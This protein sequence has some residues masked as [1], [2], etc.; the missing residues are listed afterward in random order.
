MKLIFKIVLLS[1]IFV[2]QL[3][4]QVVNLGIIK[5]LDGYT[6]VREGKQNDSKVLA[7]IYEG[8]LFAVEKSS[9]NWWK[10]ITK[11][12]I[13]GYVHKSRI[14]IVENFKK[15]NAKINDPDGYTNIRAG[16]GTNF[17]ILD[18]LYKEETFIIEKNEFSN[19]WIVKKNN[20]TIGFVHNSRIQ[21]VSP[22]LESQSNSLTNQSRASSLKYKIYWKL[23]FFPFSV[24]IGSEGLKA[25]WEV[26]LEYYTKR[27]GTFGISAEYQYNKQ[28][29]FELNGCQVKNN[30]LLVIL[31]N[32]NAKKDEVFNISD[33]KKFRIIVDGRTEVIV[34]NGQVIIDVTNGNIKDLT[35]KQ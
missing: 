18:K 28:R 11:N 19:W 35:L 20:G 23:P 5:D 17:Q 32:S 13:K 12:G 25:G 30:D 31:R 8:E 9:E 29:P 7:K 26:D 10:V 15:Y 27:L 3:P 24:S 22:Y 34:G 21:V 4:A 16:K 2:N 14:S 33:G 6:N 1:V